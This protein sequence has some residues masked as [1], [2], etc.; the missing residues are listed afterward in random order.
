MEEVKVL[1][2]PE[3]VLGLLPRVCNLPAVAPTPSLL[4]PLVFSVLYSLRDFGRGGAI[5]LLGGFL[6]VAKVFCFVVKV[7]D[8]KMVSEC[9]GQVTSSSLRVSSWF[10]PKPTVVVLIRIETQ[11][12][13]WRWC[14][15]VSSDQPVSLHLS[16]NREAEEVNEVT[17]EV[18]FNSAV[19]SLL[20]IG[21]L[22]DLPNVPVVYKHFAAFYSYSCLILE[23][24]TLGSGIKPRL[25][26]LTLMIPSLGY[27]IIHAFAV[28]SDEV[29]ISK[30]VSLID[31]T[32]R[33]SLRS[34]LA[35]GDFVNLGAFELPVS[36]T[37][38]LT[39][40]FNG[41]HS[42]MWLLA[43]LGYDS[44]LMAW[45]PVF[46]LFEGIFWQMIFGVLT[47]ICNRA[48]QQVTQNSTRHGGCPYPRDFPLILS[49]IPSP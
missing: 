20:K 47:N 16:V 2:A 9:G 3:P 48:I 28:L 31:E 34:F 41:Y 35:L 44:V 39:L 49:A 22:V 17:P 40:P 6:N 32:S 11:K 37:S 8:D 23:V 21:F 1:I 13:R 30:K 25:N 24:D 36:R 45:V 42:V 14:L 18:V 5:Q 26:C 38:A 15:E 46:A 19:V 43:S 4:T 7:L 10:L 27:S 33:F 12:G 29:N